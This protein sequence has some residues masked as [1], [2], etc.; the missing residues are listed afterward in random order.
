MFWANVC[1][2]VNG[3]RLQNVCISQQKETML[4]FLKNVF[5]N[6]PLYRTYNFITSQMLFFNDM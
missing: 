3:W 2:V 1:A 5:A 4:N 6:D